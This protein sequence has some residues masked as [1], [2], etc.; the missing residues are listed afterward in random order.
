MSI[1]NY[2]HVLHKLKSAGRYR[3]SKHEEAGT[4]LVSAPC[5]QH[6]THFGPVMVVSQLLCLIAQ[7]TIPKSSD[8]LRHCFTGVFGIPNTDNKHRRSAMVP[9]RLVC[10]MRFGGQ[11]QRHWC[12]NAKHVRIMKRFA[13]AIM[14]TSTLGVVGQIEMSHIDIQ[15]LCICKAIDDKKIG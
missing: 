15:K 12:I 8:F 1:I 14:H 9:Q 6:R 4:L 2:L 5:W 13:S 7:C 11:S 3:V 10:S